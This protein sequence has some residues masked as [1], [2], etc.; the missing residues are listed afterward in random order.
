MKLLR[1]RLFGF[2][3]FNHGLNVTFAPDRLNLVVG[4]NE[5]GKSTLLNAISGVLFGFRDLNLVRKYEPWSEHDSYSGEVEFVLDDGRRVII[6]RDFHAGTAKITQVTDGEE[7][8]LFDGS[9]DPRGAGASDRNYYETIGRLV[10]IEDESLFRNTVFVGQMSLKT[11]V[12]DQIRRLVSGS[13][14]VDYKGALHELHSRY[15]ELTHENPWK[16]KGKGKKR[17]LD[18]AREEFATAQKELERGRGQ[19][20]RCAE[21]EAEIV[22]LETRR[23]AHGVAIS[24]LQSTATTLERYCEL[25]NRRQDVERRLD[26]TRRRRDTFLQTHEKVKAL[27][28]RARREFVQFRNVSPNFPDLVGTWVSEST[29]KSRETE[30]LAA[31][32]SRLESLQ[33]SPNKKLGAVLGAILFAVPLIA[34][35]VT[36]L[37]PVPGI[38]SAVLMG[39]IG[40]MVGRNLGTGYKAQRE[41]LGR[42]VG[43]LENSVRTREKRLDDVAKETGQLLVGADAEAVLAQ[44]RDYS[45]LLDERRRHLAA[46]RTIGDSDVV[47]TQWQDVQRDHGRIEAA[48]G[49]VVATETWLAGQ[50]DPVKLG[51]EVARVRSDLAAREKERDAERERL[52]KA[53]VEHASLSARLDFDLAGLSD[54]IAQKQT[55]IKDLEV[56]K[57][58]LKEAIDTLDA[59]IKDFQENDVFRLSEEMSQIFARITGDRYTRVQLGPSLEPLVASGDRVGI[60]PE[61]LS[62]GAHD[63]LYFAMRMTV[64]RHLSSKV[65]LP[66]FLDDPFVNFDAD[67]V[68]VTRDVL[69]ALPE[70][71]VVMVTCDRA[72]EAWTDA[73]IDLDKAHNS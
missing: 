45:A 5:A 19:L 27:E 24:A 28:D 26:E 60:R 40:M 49:E 52:E 65:R 12:S 68:R 73:V 11:E 63:Q 38:I 22:T 15:A 29:E 1:V 34:G 37:G 61:D 66:I 20:D 2:G 33:P 59:C 47:N 48:I 72:Y 21:L 3:Q 44:Y 56:E 25:L 14:T 23:T 16:T 69:K 62:Q 64:V 46:L 9:A 50:S 71:Q 30:A 58:A 31:E 6:W 43:E 10:G 41:E 4:R 35:F 39:A 42:R 70:H 53:R 54:A 51:R 67:R 8:A 13:G 17:A 7:V 18:Q 36:P 55:R 57:D 32:R